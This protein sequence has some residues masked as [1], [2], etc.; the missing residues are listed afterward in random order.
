[1]RI[2]GKAVAQEARARRSQAAI[3]T[4]FQLY[5]V[6]HD[7]MRL[8]ITRQNRAVNKRMAKELVKIIPASE[9]PMPAEKFVRVLDAIITG[10]MFT[11]FQ[12]PALVTEDIFIASFE[13]LC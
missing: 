11:Y 6:T 2:L 1:M 7:S 8:Q 12:T 4:A 3:A 9:L 10:L 13:A 5:T